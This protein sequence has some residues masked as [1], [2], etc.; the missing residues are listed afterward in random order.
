MKFERAEQ[1]GVRLGMFLDG[2]VRWNVTILGSR[3]RGKTPIIHFRFC[4]NNLIEKS[5]EKLNFALPLFR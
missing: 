3:L 1:E 2:N 4:A 5:F